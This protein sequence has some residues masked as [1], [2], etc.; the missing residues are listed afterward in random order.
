MYRHVLSPP[1]ARPQ[2]KTL[3]VTGCAN[4]LLL[5]PCGGHPDPVIYNVGCANYA[6]KGRAVDT[7]DMDPKFPQK[8]WHLWDDVGGL[9]D[10]TVEKLLPLRPAGLPRYV[11]M[12]QGPHLRPSRLLNIKAVALPLFHVVG[13]K[14]DASYGAK[15]ADAA[16]LRHAYSLR[17]DARI[18]LVGVDHDAPLETLWAELD[19]PGVCESIARL[20]LEV[21]VPNYS[22]FTDVPRFQIL[23]NFKRILLTAERLSQ[24]EV[25][26]SLHINA[27][28]TGDWARF[29]SFL[30]EHSEV[31]SI[32]LEFQT[33]A[34]IDK[35]FGDGTFDELVRLVNRLSRPLH[36]ILVGAGRYYR[37][38]HQ[39][40]KNFTIIDSVP[41]MHAQAR[42]FLLKTSSGRF[43]WRSI[44]TNKNAPLHS[45]FETTLRNY[46]KKLS[47]D[48]RELAGHQPA[49]PKQ[50]L[51]LC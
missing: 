36:C 42:K 33:G 51:L 35:A 39:R 46:E 32:T 10:Y 1:G 45:L 4:C 48:G 17:K 37:S 5:T 34:R 43:T 18:L 21:T 25:R 2:P 13:R 30:Q 20:G 50:H 27:I 49:D 14:T 23:R 41:F 12:L 44:R 15:F 9:R 26:V 7:D 8:F 40:L 31:S 38:A 28:T 29:R 6:K 19:Q 3:G 47:A 24:A 16:G 22:F 11:P